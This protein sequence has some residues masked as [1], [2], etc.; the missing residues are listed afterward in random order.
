HAV[1]FRYRP[2]A[3]K[4]ALLLFGGIFILGAAITEL[5]GGLN[6]VDVGVERI[7]SRSKDRLTPDQRVLVVTIVGL[8]ALALPVCVPLL[9]T[10]LVPGH[11]AF[12][13]PPRLVEFHENIRQGV[14]LPRWAPDLSN[15]GGQPL[16]LFTPP[17]IY[18]AAEFW[19][20]LGFQATTAYN[21]TSILFVCAS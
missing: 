3:L 2:G 18:Y 14:F 12:E 17:L 16:F 11:D 21:I 7:V 6:W 5:K 8:A 10:Q 9:T 19:Y 15:G 13:Y 1:E 20:L 4:T